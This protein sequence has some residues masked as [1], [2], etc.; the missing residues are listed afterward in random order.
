MIVSL[1]LLSVNN[2]TTIAPSITTT[3]DTNIPSIAIT[4]GDHHTI[5]IHNN[6]GDV[7]IHKRQVGACHG[8]DTTDPYRDMRKEDA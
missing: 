1:R 8:G 3:T 2:I 4:R 6:R 7:T 5:T